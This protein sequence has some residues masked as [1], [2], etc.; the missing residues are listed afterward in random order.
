MNTF[1]SDKV[2]KEWNAQ[3]PQ[4]VRKVI[5]HT[6]KFSASPEKVYSLLCPTTE[7]DWMDG[8]HCETIYSKSL[9]QEYNNIFKTDYFNFPEVWVISH[10]QPNRIME[11]VRVSEHL[12]IKVD[13]RLCDNLDGTTTGDWIVNATALTEQGNM[14]LNSMNPEDEPIGIL[15][16]AAEYYLKHD[17]MQKL[18]DGIFNK[19]YSKEN[20][21]FN[22][23]TG[24]FDLA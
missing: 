21:K 2:V 1:E 13:A 14:A 9:Y 5:K 17:K 16:G 20:G 11:F 15:L 6:Q 22:S 24:L 23:K 3:G 12:S 4:Y 19:K 7:Y 10:F 8:W 18:P